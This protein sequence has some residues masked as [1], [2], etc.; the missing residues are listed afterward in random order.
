MGGGQGRRGGSGRGSSQGREGRWARQGR[1]QLAGAVARAGGE[2]G[3]A[4]EGVV[5]RGSG[6]GKGGG[7]RSR[8]GGSWQGQWPRQ[9]GEAGEAGK[10]AVAP[11][12][13]MPHVCQRTCQLS[14]CALWPVQ[15]AVP[16]LLR[17]LPAPSLPPEPCSSCV[18][19]SAWRRSTPRPPSSAGTTPRSPSSTCG[20]TRGP[21]R[22]RHLRLRALPAPQARRRRLRMRTAPAP[23]AKCPQRIPPRSSPPASPRATGVALVDLP[24]QSSRTV[25]FARR[26]MWGPVA[27]SRRQ[28]LR[29]W[30]QHPPA[31][32]LAPRRPHRRTGNGGRAL[33]RLS[34][35]GHP[36]FSLCSGL[37]R[38]ARHASWH[39]VLQ[40]SRSW[41]WRGWRTPRASNPRR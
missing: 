1:G 18:S 15:S 25:R 26:G 22:G 31:R 27:A 20:G 30:S 11:R 23:Q 39:L 17:S 5:G 37:F 13:C 28:R 33:P 4:G 10:G 29:R 34:L 21:Q 9:G 2:A 7:G 12:T 40:W 35:P 24:Q 32:L 14:L 6:Q 19:S 3:E 38:L 16:S 36:W 8:G 41:T